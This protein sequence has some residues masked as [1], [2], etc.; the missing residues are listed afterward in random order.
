[1]T[2]SRRLP[3]WG[4]RLRPHPAKPDAAATVAGF[5]WSRPKHVLVLVKGDPMIGLR[6]VLLAV[7]IACS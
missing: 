5:P 3:V 6:G 7:A 1:M 4:E 2:I